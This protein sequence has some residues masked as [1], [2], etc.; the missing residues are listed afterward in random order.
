MSPECDDLEA[1]GIR[2]VGNEPINEDD[3]QGPPCKGG[4]SLDVELVEST[5]IGAAQL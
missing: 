1:V 5:G 4:I 2:W 3:R